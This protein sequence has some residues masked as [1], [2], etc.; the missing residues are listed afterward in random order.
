VTHMCRW[1]MRSHASSI[2]IRTRFPSR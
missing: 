2:S 1:S